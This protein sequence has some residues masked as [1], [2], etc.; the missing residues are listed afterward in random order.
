MDISTLFARPAQRGAAPVK[1]FSR[2]AWLSAAALL[3]AASCTGEEPGAA[4]SGEGKLGKARS[5]LPSSDRFLAW[6]RELRA[7]APGRDVVFVD[8]D[9]VDHNIEVIKGILGPGF[10]LRLVTKSLPSLPLLRYLM[11]KAGTQR[12]M[13]FSEGLLRAMLGEI[14]GDLDILLGRPMPMEAAYRVLQAF[15]ERARGVKWLV[16]TKERMLEYKDLA[17]A[18]HRTLD[19]AI[20]LDVGL[21]RGGARTITELLAI[22]DILAA[23]PKQLRLA[24]FMGY[25]GHVPFAPQGFD[26]DAEF[27]AVQQRYDDLVKAGAQAHPQL[28]AGPLVKN[29]GGSATFYRYAAGLETPVDDVAIGSAFLLPARFSDLGATGLLPAI[30]AASPVLKKID[31]AEV[32]FAP[33]YLPQ[34]A[35]QDPS[36]EIAYFQLAGGFPGDIVYPEG[37]V[38]SPLIPA[39]EPVENLLS[40]QPLRNGSHTVPLGVGDFVFYQPWQGDALV[41]LDTAEVFRGEALVDRFSTFRDGCSKGCGS[42]RFP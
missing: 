22:L 41:W 32:P 10:A 33:G 40:N 36:L 13:A 37:L 11:K 29:G 19:V 5:P 35:Q 23:Y 17:H 18:L 24:G 39:G 21:R 14:D 34:L 31:P 4:P 12:L 8:L 3:L 30:F 15:P 1:G 25:D 2:R 26:S 7:K 38:Q 42:P 6:N 16:D 27:A 9:A 20:E 28:F